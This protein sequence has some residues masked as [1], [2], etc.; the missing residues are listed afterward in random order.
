MGQV[1][2]DIDPH[3]VAAQALV[4]MLSYLNLE[5]VIAASAPPLRADEPALRERWWRSAVELVL[6]GVR[7]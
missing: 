1:R 5:T 7:V 6:N 2:D 4:L 3:L